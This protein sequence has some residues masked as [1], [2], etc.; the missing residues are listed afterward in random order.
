MNEEYNLFSSV[1]SKKTID[2][3]KEKSEKRINELKELIY[4]YDKYYYVEAS[5]LVS[6]RDYDFIFRELQDLEKKYPDL[7][8]KDS[9]TQRVGGQAIKGF[10]SVK[11]QKQMLSL[12]NTYSREELLDFDRRVKELLGDQKYQYVTELKFDGVAISL[13]YKN[14]KFDIAVTRGDGTTGD[15]VSSNIRTMKTIPLKANDVLV[16]GKVLKDF[17][18]RGEVYMTEKDFLKINEDREELGEKTYANPRNLTAGTLKL[19]NPNI[20]ASRPMK[21][22]SYYLDTDDIKLKYHSENLKYLKH[23]GFKTSEHTRLNNNLEEVFEFIDFWESKRNELPFQIDGIVIKVDSIAQQEELGTVARSP[24]WAIAYKY[25]AESAET[26]LKDIKLQVGRMGT[27]TPVAVLEPI[28]L[29]GSTISRAT[30]HNSDYI[31]Q[32][33][34]RIGDTV[35]IQKGGE[36]IPKVVSV[37]PDKRKEDAKKYTFPDICPCELKK[38]LTRIEGEANHYC[39]APECPWQLRRKIE[40]FMSRN[41]MK[42][43]GGEKNVEQLVLAGFIKNIPDLYDLKNQRDKIEELSGWGKKSVDVLLNS[44]EESK[45]RPYSNVLY[46][47]GIRFIGEGA[48]KIIARSIKNIDEL[49]KANIDK[50]TSIYEIGEKM[51]QSIIDFFQNEENIKYINRL[52]NA[53][54]QFEMSKEDVKSEGKFTGKTFVLTGELK[55]M[56]R[57]EAKK[58]I[59][60]NGGKVTGTVSSKTSYLVVGENPGSKLKKAEKLNI[61]ILN[62]EEFI[63]LLNE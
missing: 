47:L 63:K 30:L 62:E 61:S 5:P 33:D 45:N 10:K 14:G 51:A 6:D 40:H 26:I 43:A 13:R 25:E 19:L 17:E 37:I 46:G 41:A 15:N 55:S 49:A 36:V 34:I 42:I 2:T 58:I 12:A 29:A 18:V 57:N 16:D 48:A 22:V 9:P 11:H 44:I 31:E 3:E 39:N 59:E 32:L 38:P 56:K 27:V 60:N 8:T 53:G 24:R 21:L 20:F 4:K 23:L 28:F 7:I 50:L 52:K 54:L 1:D 35:V